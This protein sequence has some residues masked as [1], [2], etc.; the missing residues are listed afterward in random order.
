MIIDTAGE[1]TCDDAC[2]RWIA[3]L[4]GAAIAAAVIAHL[5]VAALPTQLGTL[6]L[7]REGV[8]A[9]G[10]ALL[11]SVMRHDTPMGRALWL[12]GFFAHSLA[13]GAHWFGNPALVIGACLGSVTPAGTLV[14]ALL[15]VTVMG[16]I[17]GVCVPMRSGTPIAEL[18]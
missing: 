18:V 11:A 13:T 6:D 2:R 3:Q 17:V 7:V 12:A 15:G 10:L 1:R 5:D 4:L 14:G 9:C 8:A 16:M